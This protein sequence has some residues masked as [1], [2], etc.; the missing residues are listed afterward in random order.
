MQ[1]ITEPSQLS[2]ESWVRMSKKNRGHYSVSRDPETFHG[3]PRSRIGEQAEVNQWLEACHVT[4]ISATEW[5]WNEGNSFGPRVL[6]DSMAFYFD[7]VDGW[8]RIGIE[9]PFRIGP[10]SLVLIPRGVE[11]EIRHERGKAH[12]FAVHFQASIYGEIS[13]LKLLGCPYHIAVDRKDSFIEEV[14]ERLVREYAI[15]AAGWTTAMSAEIM[16][17]LVHILRTSGDLFQPLALGQIQSDLTRLLPSLVWISENIFN[18]ECRVSDMAAKINTCEGQF[19]KL[20]RRAM[21]I[22]PVHFVQRQRVDRACS[23]LL[24]TEMPITQIAEACGFSDIPFFY[25]VFRKWMAISPRNFRLNGSNRYRE[26][27]NP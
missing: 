19:R 11:H 26:E 6:N 16:T 12:L 2:V 10:R 17:L 7:Y 27:P 21:G 9:K 3:F 20:F 14:S 25:R 13:L 22:T 5:F 1:N 18:S 23:L 15:K 8:A 24:T 4:P